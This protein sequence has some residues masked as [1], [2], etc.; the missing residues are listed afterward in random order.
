MDENK[1]KK[2]LQRLESFMGEAGDELLDDEVKEHLETKLRAMLQKKGLYFTTQ[3]LKAFY[4][5][6]SFMRAAV[7][8]K[9]SN[10]EMIMLIGVRYLIRKREKEV[11]KATDAA[12]DLN[13]K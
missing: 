12:I 3:T 1:A 5:G 8:E 13:K 2:L 9:D 10:L 6:M 7:E 11:E 4:E